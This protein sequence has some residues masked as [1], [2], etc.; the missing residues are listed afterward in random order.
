MYKL[1]NEATE[2]TSNNNE[3]SNDNLVAL[4]QSVL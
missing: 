4:G 1:Q 3:M 2:L